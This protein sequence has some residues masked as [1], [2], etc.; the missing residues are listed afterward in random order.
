M[1]AR[2]I[3]ARLF[4][5][6]AL[7]RLSSPEQ[8]DTLVQVVGVRSWMALAPLLLLVL[9]ALGW[10]IFGSIPTK[11]TGK[12]ILLQTGGLREV[13]TASGGRIT[14]LPLKVGDMVRVGQPVAV[15]SQP[16][17]TSRI[18]AVEDRLRELLRQQAEQQRQVDRSREL[19]RSL[20]Q[21][22]RSALAAQEQ[23]AQE[24]IRVLGERIQS[25]QTLFEQG[26]VTRQAL[27]QS[28]NELV[29]Q[30]QAVQ[31]VRGELQQVALRA[32]EDEKRALQELTLSGNQ[33][34]EARR[35]L[36]GLQ[37]RM[38]EASRIV[39]SHAGRVV[40][41][42]VGPGSLVE[43]GSALVTLETGD[44]A[45]RR[46]E[47]VIYIPAAEGKKVTPG[48]Q[49]QV[50]PSTARRE[51]YGFMVGNVRSVSDYAA[52]PESMLGVLQNRQLVQE[53]AAGA[54]PIEVRVDLQP[55]ATASGFE[56]SSREGPPFA[57]RSGTLGTAEIVV[58]RQAPVTL[59]IPVLKKSLGLD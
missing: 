35:E 59:V 36:E 53:L 10:G 23:A 32:A 55:A 16:D 54:S 21:Q 27:L 40:E 8:L 26:L 57:V 50:V 20:V 45:A 47:A 30:Q 14:E 56:W 2:D 34:S 6:V 15:L 19:G 58:S 38:Q 12:F 28:R 22:Q 39:S 43:P 1:E 7:D 4:R 48:M 52:T 24:R 46:M 37:A 11:V 25:Q 41:I 9:L 13:T 49:A 42:K 3:K 5:K 29:A 33:V 44:A 31:Q 51:E 17:L 18:R